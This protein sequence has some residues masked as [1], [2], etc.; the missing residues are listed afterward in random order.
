V[1]GF[2]TA[3]GLGLRKLNAGLLQRKQL[4]GIFPCRIGYQN[5]H[6]LNRHQLSSN[7]R[8]GHSGFPG[9]SVLNSLVGKSF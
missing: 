6:L 7:A 8:D 5:E 9:N 2:N 3:A 4:L 1:I